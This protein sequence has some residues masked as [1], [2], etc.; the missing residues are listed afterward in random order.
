M[1]R[2]ALAVLGLCLITVVSLGQITSKTGSAE[3]ADSRAIR[4][5]ETEWLQA[6]RTTD[7]SIVERILADDYANLTPT[8]T[9]PGGADLVRNFKAH[10]GSAPPYSV[11][12]H[13]LRIFVLNDKS[14]I[15]TYVKEYV[16][17]EN[18]NVARQDMTDVFTKNAQ[19]WKMRLSR[20]SPHAE[21]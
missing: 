7:P 21:D 8:G 16:A 15:A 2:N 14:A 6:E 3:S 18:G 4:Q 12:E 13:S 19:G 9:G 1:M 17:N 11:R 20:T 5:L 10:S